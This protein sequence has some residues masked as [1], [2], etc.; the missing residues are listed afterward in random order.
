MPRRTPQ[1]RPDPIEDAIRR[2]GTIGALER[3]A[4]IGQD[5]DDR[6]T[7]WKPFTYLPGAAGLD[8]GCEELKRRIRAQAAA[9]KDTRGRRKGSACEAE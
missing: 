4:G 1:P 7:F 8:A 6:Y 3:L 9:T 5:G 2:A